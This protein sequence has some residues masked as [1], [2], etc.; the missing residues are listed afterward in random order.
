ML[1]TLPKSA[2]V[3]CT[4]AL[5]F[6]PASKGL[7]QFIVTNNFYG[8]NPVNGATGTF[9]TGVSVCDFD[10]DGLDDLSFGT[11]STPP[12][13]YRNTGSGFTQVP[14]NHPSPDKP[15]KSII[16]ADI[17]ND[18]DRDLFLS[19]EFD[20]VRLYE[21]VGDLELV[22]I[23]E[24][25][26]IA[27][28]FN[29]RNAGA[30]FGD[31]D[32]DGFIDL[33]L[34][35]YYN[36]MAFQGPIYENVLYRNKGDNTFENVTFEAQASV[37]VNASF[38]AVW[39]DYDQ[40][41]WLD[42]FIVNDRVFNQNY[43]LRNNGNGGFTDVS[44]Q[45]GVNHFTDAMGCAL[46]DYNN[47]LLMD[48]YVANSELQGNYLYQQQP[49]YSFQE[50]GEEAGVRMYELCWS[51]LWMDFDNDGWQDLHV[52]AEIN[53][54][55]QMAPNHLY[56]NLGNGSFVNYT[57]A[58]GLS[59]DHFS[60]FSTAGGDWN[61]DGYPDFVCS[62]APPHQSLLWQNVGGNG[63]YLAVSL[64]GTVSN[65]DAIGAKI[66]AFSG[67]LHQIRYVTSG[68][69]HIG[70]N[71]Y[72]KLF[73]LANHTLVDSLIIK[74]PSGLTEKYENLQVNTT[75]H[76]VEGNSLSAYIITENLSFCENES[77]QLTASIDLPI[78]WSNGETTA[79][80]SVTEPGSYWY[81]VN[82]PSGLALPSDTVELNS[83]PLSTYQFTI[84]Q[85]SCNGL[86]DGTLSIFNDTGT[87][88][89]SFFIN[90]Q[91]AQATTSSLAAGDYE[92]SIVDLFGCSLTQVFTLSEPENLQ[93]IALVEP[94]DCFGETTGVTGFAFGGVPP[95]NFDWNG[96][97]P[98][99]LSAGDYALN[100]SDANG[101]QLTT[102]FTVTEP[103]PLTVGIHQ[104]GELLLAEVEGGTP[105]Y[106]Y[107]WVAPGG[108]TDS[109]QSLEAVE[110]GYYILA[111]TDNNGCF[112]STV[113]PVTV[114]A[115][116]EMLH[117]AP[118]VYPNPGDDLVHV[119]THGERIA[120]IALYDSS[121][122][123]IFRSAS[124]WSESAVLDVS[125]VESGSYVLWMLMEDG[126]SHRLRLSVVH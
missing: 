109:N 31:Y 16:W 67:D 53:Q 44:E 30:A 17:D 61:N 66:Y 119:Q 11:K 64:Q 114:T 100:I 12:L 36:S 54:V 92:I 121:G 48:F 24:S 95:Y 113:A 46:G 41:G 108:A 49:D 9:G 103:D 94:I 84:T 4:I 102:P 13:L 87:Y 99:L 51:G 37:G 68:E 15:I 124:R 89:V 45:T 33:Y 69:N 85:P 52:A 76:F 56:K 71:S 28:E 117:Q 21:N 1:P 80:I 106:T 104:E 50:V 98:Q 72:R 14:F 74:W 83:V 107:F 47:D 6:A 126:H 58:A 116:D 19:Y 96:N 22:D 25:S 5:A 32:N 101:C 70:Q 60:T 110:N 38:N 122:K 59:L 20:S 34:C 39:W 7:A 112:E 8:V 26:G 27:M 111:V 115:V 78:T 97:D 91:E 57:Q 75:H 81:V 73:G 40:D 88:D 55:G 2:V 86:Q 79:S 35:K 82:H 43:L 118:V 10:G 63:N 105:P 125:G 90:G 3:L 120:Q 23:T 123:E 62:N 29:I 93:A 42:I 18:G 77:V 65:R